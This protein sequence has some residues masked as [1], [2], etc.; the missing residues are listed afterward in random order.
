[1][2]IAE[3]TADSIA[4]EPADIWDGTIVPVDPLPADGSLEMIV[5]WRP[6]GVSTMTV[7]GVVPV[8]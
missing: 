6:V 5:D 3:G 8:G 7:L 1:V 4:S 2:A